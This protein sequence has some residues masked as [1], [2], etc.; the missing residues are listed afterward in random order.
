MFSMSAAVVTVLLSGELK[1]Y[2]CKVIQKL[3]E[4]SLWIYLLEGHFLRWKGYL[5]GSNSGILVNLIAISMCI[6]VGHMCYQL[7]N[8][9]R[10]KAGG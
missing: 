2:K 10:N 6:F 4:S 7:N 9:I 1:L 5:F 3:G 8:V